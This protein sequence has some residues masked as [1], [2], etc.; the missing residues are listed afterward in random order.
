MNGLTADWTGPGG[1]G[2][3]GRSNGNT[4]EVVNNAHT[5]IRNQEFDA[6]LAT[7]TD[8]GEKFDVLVVGG[9][10]S[11]LS[12]AW[13]VH[14]QRAHSKILVLDQHPMFG[15]EAK[16]NEFEVDGTHLW[17]P[18]GSTGMVFPLARAKNIGFYS[19]FY[20]ELGF[21]QEFKFQQAQ[22][23]SVKV[24]R[25]IWSPMHI[26]WEQ[27]DIGYY[28]EGKGWVKNAWHNGWKDAPIPDELKYDLTRM[29][30]NRTPPER[31]DWESWLD[32]MT[33]LDYLTQVM[34]L[35]PDVTRYLNHQTCSMGCGLGADV[36]SAYSAFN[37]M[38]PG[39]IGYLRDIEKGIGDPADQV[40]LVTLPG[41]NAGI[42]RRL[43]Q[44]MIPDAFAGPSMS[45]LLLGSVHLPS[46]D[47]PH[48]AVRLRL[49]ST[50]LAVVH[51]SGRSSAKGVTVFYRNGDKLYKVHG[52]SVIMAGQQ[53]ANRHTPQSDAAHAGAAR[54]ATQQAGRTTPRGELGQSVE[55]DCGYGRSVA[56][57]G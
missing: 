39:V 14:K 9:G 4:H 40:Y 56:S 7:A 41:G 34:G 11:G 32:T 43:V 16:Q 49:S 37:F 29:D 38:Q 26:G 57:A 30:L 23:T 13:T 35:S 45:K 21:P 50:V 36:I 3:Y 10:I 17:A 15:G 54:R 6:F 27:A 28:F 51:D 25:D 44:K 12:A 47:R 1:I 19:K 18:Q 31:K 22:N 52:K 5:G 42:A 55:H 20:D 53:H 2:D 24:P 48:Q 46:L 33:Y 8:T